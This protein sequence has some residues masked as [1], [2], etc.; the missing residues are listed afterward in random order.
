VSWSLLGLR[1]KLTRIAIIVGVVLGVAAILA[2]IVAGVRDVDR[3]HR[4]CVGPHKTW[5]STEDECVVEV[6]FGGRQ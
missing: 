1:Q 2:L 6:G 4:E 5:D 3:R